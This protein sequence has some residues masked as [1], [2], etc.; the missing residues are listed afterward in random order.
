MVLQPHHSPESITLDHII[1]GMVVMCHLTYLVIRDQESIAII[2][3]V[4]K[5]FLL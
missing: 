5:R 4:T 2:T 1:E 3:F